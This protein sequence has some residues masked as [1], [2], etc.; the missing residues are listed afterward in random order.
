MELPNI[1][2]AARPNFRTPPTQA[3][4]VYDPVGL[5]IYC[6]SVD[7]L[8]D[9]HVVPYGLGG[10][11]ILP[12][13]S[14]RD[15]AR[16]TGEF[17]GHVLRGLWWLTRA[18]LGYPTRR[19]KEMPKE[20]RLNV[21]TKGGE[22]KEL[23]LGPEEKFAMAGFPEYAP[24]AS[25]SNYKYTHGIM[26]TGHR[27]VGFGDV[28][29]VLVKKYDVQTI[30]GSLSYKGTTFPR[31]L[32]KIAYGFAVGSFGIDAFEQ[33]YVTDSILDK[34][35]DVGMWVGG[36]DRPSTKESA[37]LESKQQNAVSMMV[38]DDRD[39]YFRIRLF[40]FCPHSPAYRVRVARLKPDIPIAPVF[41]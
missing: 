14:C 2:A 13:A 32:A 27:L 39:I 37:D 15:C 1:F 17:E 31:M 8:T 28:V 5:C 25:V 29:E 7:D 38:G 16:I 23:V 3:T 22:T 26:M 19:K 12:Q 35:D 30:N 9:E 34:K 41:L 4:K 11:H 6:G 21:T 18:T 40:A 10:R 33:V 24:P 36:D 20:Y